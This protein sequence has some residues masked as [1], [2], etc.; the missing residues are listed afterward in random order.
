MAVMTMMVMVYDM[1]SH[2]GKH[3]SFHM[4]IFEVLVAVMQGPVVVIMGYFREFCDIG[5]L[6]REMMIY[7]TICPRCCHTYK[8]Q[9]ANYHSNFYHP[10]FHWD[11]SYVKRFCLFRRPGSQKVYH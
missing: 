1:V 2:N 9:N 3:R 6:F 10:G 11:T 7:A 5:N 4:K 8:K